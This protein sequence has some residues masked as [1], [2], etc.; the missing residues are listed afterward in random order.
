MFEMSLF[1]ITIFHYPL[2]PCV[3]MSLSFIY[4]FIKFQG[5][6]GFI[7]AHQLIRRVLSIPGATVQHNYLSLSPP[8]HVKS[9][10]FVYL[11]IKFQGE[12]GFILAHQLIRRALSIPGATVHWYDKPG[13]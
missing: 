3:K 9:L 4:L 11:F 12:P 13:K 5:A 2:P 8:P 6:P 7:L 10:T 1:S